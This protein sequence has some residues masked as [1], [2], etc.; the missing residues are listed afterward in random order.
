MRIGLASIHPRP[1]SGQI[2]GLVGLAQALE[3]RGHAVTVISAFPSDELLRQDRLQLAGKRNPS[4]LGHP[5][6]VARILSKLVRLSFHIDLIQLNLPT[7]AFSF[8]ADFLQALVRVPVLVYYEAHL[9]D[10]R[11]LLRLDRLS[12]A[13]E[14]YVPRLLINN[15]L[16]AR[17]AP[18][19]AARYLVSSK[20]QRAELQALGIDASRIRLLPNLMPPDKLARPL[21]AA[22]EARSARARL[23][24]PAGRLVTYVGHYNHIKGVD[25]LASAFEELAAHFD[26]AHLVLAWSGQ[27]SSPR[28]D[29]L[30]RHPTLG[31]R[32]IQLGKVNVP[33]LLAA[34]D[35]VVLPYRLTI[36]Q[37]VYPA[38]LLEAIAAN[39][40]VVTSD[41]PLLRELTNHGKTA[42]LAPPED[43][44]A[45]ARAIERLW[46]EPHLVRAMLAAQ[47]DWLW[48]NQP[49]H[50][51]RDYER[52]YEQITAQQ[53][54]VL[55]PVKSRAD[56][57]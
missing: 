1:L 29:E 48:R 42:L 36:G 56:I 6:R 30:R 47:Q 12:Q 40:P 41:L 25:V 8:V 37:A 23:N 57:R 7:P 14:F 44:A 3:K 35:A 27:G 15:Q 45:L 24:L 4:M 55:Q 28:V 39:V 43:P 51:V 5:V 34:S 53:T 49:Q 38:A 21:R 33:D 54:T 11:D 9:V 50:V 32:V 19:R 16:V 46:V 26:D 2:E 20:Y 17:L 31:A 22:G 13:P 18:W 52:V 10:A